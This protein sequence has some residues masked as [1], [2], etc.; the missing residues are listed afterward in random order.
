MA[1][2]PDWGRVSDRD[3]FRELVTLRRRFVVPA[4]IVFVVWFGGFLLLAA[5]ARDFMGKTPIGDISWAYILALSQILMAWGIA[6][7]Y[8]RFADR[9][10]SPRAGDLV[11]QEEEAER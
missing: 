2:A 1:Q 11:R 9:E 10:L 4:L 5:F 6:F 8:V 3:E 7:A